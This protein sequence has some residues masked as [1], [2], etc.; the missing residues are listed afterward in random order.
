LLAEDELAWT[1]LTAKIIKL[2]KN[3]S[4]CGLKPVEENSNGK[5]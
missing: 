5:F 2:I 3:Q 4:N 1:K